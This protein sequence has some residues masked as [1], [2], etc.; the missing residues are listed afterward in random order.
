M[1]QRSVGRRSASSVAQRPS[2]MRWRPSPPCMV[3]VRIL[4]TTKRRERRHELIEAIRSEGRRD[5][6]PSHAGRRGRCD[7]GN[8][9]SRKGVRPGR[10]RTC[11]PA[12]DDHPAAA[13]F[14]PQRRADDLLHRSRHPH[15]SIRLQRARPAQQRH[16]AAVDRRAV[17][18]RA[19]VE[20][21]GP[22]SGVERH[23]QQPPAALARGRRARE[24][25]PQPVEQQQ[26]QHV[27]LP[28]PP[29]FVRAP[30]APRRALRARRL[31]DRARRRLSTASG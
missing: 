7:R 15:R 1:P 17:V 29:A 8:S 28:G 21:A 22:L 2:D 25:L 18:G 4:P 12:V 24:R 23:S 3:L 10:A 27:R 20:R 30:D 9:R 14:Q 6:V 13:R 19:G 11:R 31:G 16:P 26:R 5:A